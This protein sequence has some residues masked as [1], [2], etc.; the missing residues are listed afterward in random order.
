MLVRQMVSESN[1]F[2]VQEDQPKKQLNPRHNPHQADF[3]RERSQLC[4][5]YHIKSPGK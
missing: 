5:D 3:F 1:L 2:I 4:L